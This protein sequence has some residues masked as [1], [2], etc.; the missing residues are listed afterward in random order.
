MAAV[1]LLPNFLKRSLERVLP[2]SLQVL[3][4][5]YDKLFKQTDMLDGDVGSE[6]TYGVEREDV[7]PI[8][9][10]NKES[11]AYTAFRFA[12]IFSVQE[13]VYNELKDRLPSF[14]PRQVLDFGAGPGQTHWAV[15]QVFDK[16]GA[17]HDY[18]EQVSTIL[19]NETHEKNKS[20]NHGNSNKSQ[21]PI[22]FT[23]IEESMAMQDIGKEICKP[24][25]HLSKSITWYNSIRDIFENPKEE[26]KQYDMAVLSYTLG[27]N[28]SQNAQNAIVQL[29]W[30]KLSEDGILVVIEKGT[31]H[32]FSVLSEVRN[33]AIDGNKKNNY[34]TMV[35][36]LEERNKHP[37]VTNTD[38][39]RSDFRLNKND[40]DE[41]M[42]GATMLHSKTK[43]KKHKK[44]KR[45]QNKRHVAFQ[46]ND[47]NIIAPC[48][49]MFECPMTYYGVDP[50]LLCRFPIRVETPYSSYFK[51]E[52][53][54]YLILQKKSNFQKEAIFQNL[55]LNKIDIHGRAIQPPRK[56][57]SHVIL[58]LCTNRGDLESLTVTKKYNR[59]IPSLYRKSRKLPWGKLWPDLTERQRIMEDVSNE[60]NDDEYYVDD[61]MFKD[62]DDKK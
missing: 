29:C 14:Q 17:F 49:H 50:N 3:Q 33:L 6:D 27:E 20:N 43:N 58:D 53:F 10:G 15:N 42:K 44:K 40:T 31:P 2:T 32:G 24:F 57:K 55:A 21:I 11:A 26:N 60:L 1:K 38:D 28:P 51:M 61:E 52:Y 30:E 16:N 48:P 13:Y 7:T 18:N 34:D 45:K 4:K 46:L 23:Y 35:H 12:P 41:N 22:Q 62:L 19:N 36:S 37:Y 56:R 47:A 59:I 54:T 5:D 39:D 25:K 9:Y 8:S